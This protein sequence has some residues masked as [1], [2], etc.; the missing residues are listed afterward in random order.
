MLDLL[1][2]QIQHIGTPSRIIVIL[3]TEQQQ[4]GKGILLLEVVLKIFGPSGAAPA[5]LEHTLGKFNDILLG[6]AFVFL[7]EVMFAG[8]RKSADAIKTL[9]TTTR[10]TIETKGLPVVE[11]PVALNLWLASNHPNAAHIE[12]HDAR[13]WAPK[14]SPHRY[15]DVAYFAALMTQIENG[16]REAFA[17]FSAHPRCL[18][19]RPMARRA[20]GERRQNPDDP[21]QHKPLRC[22]QMDRRLLPYRQADRQKIQRR[23]RLDRLDRRP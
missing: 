12:E 8:D 16:G 6:K 15:G 7:D 14:V 19:F 11:Y 4:T 3:Q 23:R 17:H 2:W 10:H 9:S 13:Y 20:K 1:A 21:T 22:A 5:M 18:Q